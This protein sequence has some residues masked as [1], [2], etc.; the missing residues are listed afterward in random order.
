MSENTIMNVLVLGASGAGKSTLIKAVSGAKVMTGIGEGNTQKIDVYESDTWPISFIDTKGFEYSRIEQ[1]KTIKQVKEYTKSQIQHSDDSDNSDDSG[2]DAV[3]YCV[4]GTSRRTFSHNIE[5]MNK[6]I[7]KWKNIPV[8][9]VITKSYSESDI[10]EN[11][12]AVKE[13]FE[14]VK[15]I[16]LLGIFPV[17]AEPYSINDEVS[18]PV[19]GIA[20]L[21]KATI[22]CTDTAKL[23]SKENIARMVLEQKRY[24]ANAAITVAA[25]TAVTVGAVPLAFADAVL[26]TPIETVLAQ[27]ILK[28]YGAEV[29]GDFISSIIGSA[30]IANVAKFA[31]NSLKG[32]PIAGSVLNGAFAGVV[33]V[34]IGEAVI[35][36]S[37]AIYTGK[38]DPKK[39]DEAVN[40][41]QEKITENPVLGEVVK[42][43]KENSDKLIDKDAKEIFDII[44][45]SVLKSLKK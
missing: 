14:K 19:R 18:V 25:A 36:L 41:V 9:A 29:T 11:I 6:A 32:L 33:V 10:S 12:Q 40:F 1:H 28:T 34:V 24:Q 17:V 20:E 39:V 45:K 13:A 23:I 16:N 26:L 3:W 5:L 37:E 7:K 42:Y 30:A 43:F 27:V 31:L 2:I 35:A 21:C 4:E 38:I 8:F 22:S 44:Y 15:K